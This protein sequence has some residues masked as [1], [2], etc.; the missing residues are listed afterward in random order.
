MAVKELKFNWKNAF[1]REKKFD[2]QGRISQVTCSVAM[3]YLSRFQTYSNFR[4]RF[5][6]CFWP[7][8]WHSTRFPQ[9]PLHFSWE[10]KQNT[11]CDSFE[12]KDNCKT[13][14]K[15]LLHS[16][17]RKRV[18]LWANW[19]RETPAWHRESENE[20]PVLSLRSLIPWPRTFF[21][22]DNSKN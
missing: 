5:H 16:A 7:L 18:K 9:V 21:S 19:K 3:F 22:I 10:W 12:S 4:K 6:R 17:R 13:R 14:R 20:G 1:K 8:F 11:I 15:S 2:A